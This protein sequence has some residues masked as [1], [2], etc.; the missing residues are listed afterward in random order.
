MFVVEIVKTFSDWSVN[1]KHMSDLIPFSK[2]SLKGT[3]L[4][5]FEVIT[6]SVVDT[7][8]QLFLMVRP[9]EVLFVVM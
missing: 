3:K 9:C 6:S 1:I 4:V 5:I 8:P 7:V 2:G